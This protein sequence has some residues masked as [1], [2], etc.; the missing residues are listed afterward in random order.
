[1]TNNPPLQTNPS[2]SEAVERTDKAE[3]PDL[4]YVLA[5]KESLDDPNWQP[6]RAVW[7]DLCS[8]AMTILQS[9]SVDE[10]VIARARDAIADLLQALDAAD[11][12][13]RGDFYHERKEARAVL[14]TLGMVR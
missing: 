2:L 8:T 12:V 7:A 6:N 14:D 1:M 4:L 11:S 13:K 9:L 5:C 3:H 10:E